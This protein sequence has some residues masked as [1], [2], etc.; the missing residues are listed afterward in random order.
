M[1]AV[2]AGG[3]ARRVSKVPVIYTTQSKVHK[4]WESHKCWAAALW[5]ALGGLVPS[6][7][8][9]VMMSISAFAP[10]LR[11]SSPVIMWSGDSGLGAHDVYGFEPFELPC[12]PSGGRLNIRELNEPPPRMGGR[13][14]DDHEED[15][16]MMRTIQH[17]VDA[18]YDDPSSAAGVGGEVWPAAEIMCRWLRDS[19]DEIGGARVL[20]LG[21]GTGACGLYA[22]CLGASH[23]FLTDGSDALRALCA[24]NAEANAHL[25]VPGAATRVEVES[26][27]WGGCMLPPRIASCGG[28]DL[29]IGSDVTYG[30][31]AHEELAQSLAALLRAPR[32]AQC[33]APRVVL[34][35]E[36]RSRDYGLPWLKQELPR[37]D[38]ADEHLAAFAPAAAAEGLALRL[39]WQERPRCTERGT[40]RSWSAD[41]SVFEVRL[42]RRNTSGSATPGDDAP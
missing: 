15:D 39:L 41:L 32:P 35:H 42:Q 20:E 40:F 4:G 7:T 30:H 14:K 25:L 37:W 34:A 17:F 8:R 13:N 21:S 19:A 28:F 5:A 2:S 1:L 18:C 3:L 31:D 6:T 16:A 10:F 24:S 38:A 11:V 9:P 27:A 29:I 36:H 26:F 33:R 12:L 22:A 23:V